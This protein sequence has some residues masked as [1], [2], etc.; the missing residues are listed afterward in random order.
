MS[1]DPFADAIPTGDP[2]DLPSSA[3]PGLDYAGFW[4]RFVASAIDS[5]L[6]MLVI[7]PLVRFFFANRH[8]VTTQIFDSRGISSYSF[9]GV[10]GVSPLGQLIYFLIVLAVVMLFWIYRAATPGKILLGLKILDAKT[11]QPLSKQQAIVRYFGYYLSTLFFGL[12]FIWAAFDRRKQAWHD[13]IAGTVVVYKDQT[14]K[15][16]D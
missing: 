12:G 6:I 11:A 15:S 9:E 16:P 3:K 4:I 13:K 10:Y 8:S 5:I 7:A 1:I 14:I 2:E